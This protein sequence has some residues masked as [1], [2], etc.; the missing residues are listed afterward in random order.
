MLYLELGSEHG[1][2]HL[3]NVLKMAGLV[4][5]TSAAHRMLNQKAVKIDSAKVEENIFIKKG[6]EHIYQIGKRKFAKIKLK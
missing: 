2:L 1:G 3:V 4:E 5:S 6:E